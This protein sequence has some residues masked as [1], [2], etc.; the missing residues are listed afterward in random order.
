MQMNVTHQPD[1]QKIWSR[2]GDLNPG[3]THYEFLPT[4][5]GWVTMS[6]YDWSFS[7][8]VITVTHP[9]S[10]RFRAFC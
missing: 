5:A 10:W 1:L 6:H 2:L 8:V 4:V 9:F 7:E 3:P